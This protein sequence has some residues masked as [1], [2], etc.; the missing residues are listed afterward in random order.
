MNRAA[1]FVVWKLVQQAFEG[2]SRCPKQEQ[3]QDGDEKDHWI[4]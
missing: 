3:R 2:I 4:G 1:L